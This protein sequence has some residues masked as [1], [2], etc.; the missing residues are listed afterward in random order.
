MAKGMGFVLLLLAGITGL[1]GAYYWL[2]S[3]KVQIV[4]ISDFEPLDEA[5][6]ATWW[7]AALMTAFQES[8]MLN[9]R[10]AGFTALSVGLASIAGFVQML[11]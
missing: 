3:A 1:I 10:A 8:A 7:N 6:K 5:D 4:P 11:G 2:R 9:K